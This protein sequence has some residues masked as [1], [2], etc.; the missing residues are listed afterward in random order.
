[1]N[2][3]FIMLLSFMI[4]FNGANILWFILDVKSG[5]QCMIELSITSIILLIVYL[6][7]K[8]KNKKHV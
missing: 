3:A 7:I 4:G 1:M 8:H 2:K 6:I 5:K